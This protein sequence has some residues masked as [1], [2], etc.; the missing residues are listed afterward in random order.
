MRENGCDRKFWRDNRMKGGAVFEPLLISLHLL[1]LCTDQHPS[2]L[3]SFLSMR[4]AELT[5]FNKMHVSSFNNLSGLYHLL[6]K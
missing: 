6:E 2:A 1:H 4:L 3:S 5:V